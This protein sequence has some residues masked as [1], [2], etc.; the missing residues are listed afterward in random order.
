MLHIIAVQA[1]VQHNGFDGTADLLDR[2]QF[3]DAF[4]QCALFLNVIG[5]KLFV[6]DRGGV[7]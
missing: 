3:K 7:S 5:K 2:G 6:D 1:K 4:R